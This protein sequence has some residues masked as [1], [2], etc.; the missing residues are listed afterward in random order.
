MSNRLVPCCLLVAACASSPHADPPA[1]SAAAAGWLELFDGKSLEGWVTEGGRYDGSAKWTIEDG[2]ITGRVDE[3]GRGGLLY[4]AQAYSA[5]EFECDVR[6]D[7]PFDSGIFLRMRP[8]ARGAQVT[9]DHR[10]DGEIAA[11]YS[12]GFLAHNTAAA[13]EFKAGE[14]NHVRVRCTGFD[15]HIVVH[16]NGI[17]V[18]DYVLPEG[19]AGFAPS[20]LIGLQVHG[21]R[22]DPPS[23][24]V[25]FKNVR[26][27]ELEVFE[28]G[29]FV[30]SGDGRVEPSPE[31][32]RAGWRS[33]VDQG[34]DR[35]EPSGSTEGYRIENG[36]IAVPARGSGEL[37]SRE[38]FRDFC[39]RVDFKI[40]RMANSGLY[41][42]SGRGGTNPSFDGCEVQILDDFNW[43]RET[44]ST[45]LPYQLTGGLYG[46]VAPGRKRF[47]PIGSWN[48]Y[49]VLY[50]GTRLAVALNGLILYDVD[51]SAVPVGEHPPFAER[52]SQGFIGFQR[53][54]APGVEEPV[55]AWFRNVLVRPLE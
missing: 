9:L 11:I 53:Y 34:L 14:W 10:P 16:L 5:F 3:Q 20:G 45:L 28:P 44:N 7:H 36:V 32:A 21:D 19:S 1:E 55:A 48:R 49:E 51:T 26:L 27:R 29:T 50:R 52:P 4:T 37:R 15:M 23:H 8:D 31:A 54:G 13:R 6:M 39:L 18:T 2:A 22:S 42:R 41:L 46:S 38:D 43:E 17:Q 40:A 12:D 25:Q 33:L 24:R 35:W 30:D 47:L